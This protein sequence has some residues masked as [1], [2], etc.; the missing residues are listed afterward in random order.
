M[1]ELAPKCSLWTHRITLVWAFAPVVFARLSLADIETRLFWL[2]PHVSFSRV[3]FFALAIS[4]YLI[5]LAHPFR[6]KTERLQDW[7]GGSLDLGGS[8]RRGRVEGRLVLFGNR[9]RQRHRLNRSLGSQMGNGEEEF[10]S[11]CLGAC[12]RNDEGQSIEVW[13]S[14]GGIA[15]GY[16][17]RLNGAANVIAAV[18]CWARSQRESAWKLPF[19]LGFAR[20]TLPRL[21]DSE[22]CSIGR[23]SSNPLGAQ[24]NAIQSSCWIAESW[25]ADRV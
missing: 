14:G 10:V 8:F 6:G 20:E 17:A 3:R 15:K 9:Q 23:G 4:W 12:A 21:R 2:L 22:A 16:V 18:F 25:V 11:E 19:R 7:K 5:H 24:G 1:S 13:D